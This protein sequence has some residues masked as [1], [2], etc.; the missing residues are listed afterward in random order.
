[1]FYL[2]NVP[3]N[4]FISVKY[5]TVKSFKLHFLQNSPLVQI[6]I[7]ATDYNGVGDIPGSHF[8]KPFQ[9]FRRLLNDVCSVTIAP[10]LKC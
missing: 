7:S 1:M 4:R 3:R 9:I 10:F 8:L 6:Y 2:H 5:K